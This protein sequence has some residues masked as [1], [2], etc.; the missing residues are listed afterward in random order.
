MSRTK[1]EKPKFIKC[2][3]CGYKERHILEPD[4]KPDIEGL[5][6]VYLII[7]S[8]CRHPSLSIL[9]DLSLPEVQDYINELME[10]NP[11]LRSH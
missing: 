2:N 3:N 11:I 8:N 9:G 10:R 1:G 4:E 5:T 7:C 6:A